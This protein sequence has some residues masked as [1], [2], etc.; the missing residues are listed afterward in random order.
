[1]PKAGNSVK[2]AGEV[3]ANLIKQTPDHLRTYLH[4]FSTQTTKPSSEGFVVS[5]V[6]R[7]CS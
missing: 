3:E 2:V 4:D 7:K 5:G 6:W 1:M